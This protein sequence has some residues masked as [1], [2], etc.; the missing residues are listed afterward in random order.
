MPKAYGHPWQLNS[1][2]CNDSNRLNDCAKI[3][4][5]DLRY[6]QLS[7]A[8]IGT[9][10]SDH[11]GTPQ[12]A[13]RIDRGITGDEKREKLFRSDASVSSLRTASPNN[14][15]ETETIVRDDEISKRTIEKI[16][17]RLKPTI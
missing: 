13:R 12:C 14:S 16:V 1:K 8:M 5:D 3:A 2:E 9:A 10:A 4:R 7:R 15:Q 11:S 6:K 17:R